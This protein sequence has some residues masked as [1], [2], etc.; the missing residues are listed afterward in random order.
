LKHRK[1]PLPPSWN[2]RIDWVRWF[3][4]CRWSKLAD[5]SYFEF[6]VAWIKYNYAFSTFNIGITY[7]KL[8]SKPIQFHINIFSTFSP[9]LPSVNF[10]IR[11]FSSFGYVLH[12][13]FFYLWSYSTFRYSMFGLSTFGHSTFGLFLPSVILHSV[14]LRSVFLP[15]S[16]F[17]QSFYIHSVTVS[18]KKLPRK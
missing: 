10:S 13:G 4:F 6:V 12:S 18:F 3:I 1:C 5:L 17:V 9:F 11:S 2:A 15:Q 7:Y 16:F 14:I 8:Y